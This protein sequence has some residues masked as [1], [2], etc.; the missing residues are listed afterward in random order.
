M[1]DFCNKTSGTL[2]Q[3]Q[4]VSG[5]DYYVL[6]HSASVEKV[7]DVRRAAQFLGIPAGVVTVT[8]VLK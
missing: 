1:K 4:A 7:A 8:E 2:Y 6:T 5:T 3:H